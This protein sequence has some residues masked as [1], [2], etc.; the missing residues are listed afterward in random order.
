MQDWEQGSESR[1]EPASVQCKHK[2]RSDEDKEEECLDEDAHVECS[3]CSRWVRASD[4][5]VASLTVSEVAE[6]EVF[7]LR[8]IYN[9]LVESRRAWRES[10]DENKADL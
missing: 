1:V 4:V 7:C 2:I 8:C 5:D 6:M 3:G 10:R 9:T